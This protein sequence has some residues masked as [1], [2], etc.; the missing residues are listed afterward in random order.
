MRI[1]VDASVILAILIGA[2]VGA[3]IG[4]G[5]TVYVDY[6]DDGEV[7]NGSVSA[8]DYVAN[9]LVAGVVGGVSGGLSSA[10]T[11]AVTSFLSTSFPIMIP[12]MVNGAAGAVAVT[13]TGAQIV[14]GAVATVA[15][16]GL[17]HMAYDGKKAA[18]RIKSNSKKQAYDKAFYKGGKKEPTY[19]PN[20]K[21]GPHYHPAN[22][23]FKHWHYYFL[24]IW[25]MLGLT[26]E[27]LN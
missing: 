22:P 1:R 23:K 2:L 12:T 24:F 7:F 8:Q 13:V 9:T 16:I 18:P 20:G 4:F 27:S 6:T 17:L 3:T 15:G 5:A 19:H 21:Y 26:S 11:P 10:L 25:G 14:G